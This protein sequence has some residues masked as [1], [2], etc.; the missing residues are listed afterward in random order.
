MLGGRRD[1][2]VF[3]VARID[4]ACDVASSTQPHKTTLG[5]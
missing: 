2:R 4:I 3:V 1:H 5:P